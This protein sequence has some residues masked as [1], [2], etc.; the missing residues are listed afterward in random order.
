MSIKLTKDFPMDFYWGG[1]VTATQTEGNWDVDGK[2]VCPPDL[3]YYEPGKTQNDTMTT[4]EIQAALDDQEH[5]YPR[6]HA[7]DFYH[8]YKEDI[9]LLKEM[10][11]NSFRTSI[12]W[13]RIFPNGDDLEPNPKGIEF[14]DNVINELLKNDIEPIITLSHFEMPINLSLKY[15]GWYSRE[16]IQFF[17]K[18]VESLFIHFKGRVKYWIPFDE[19]NLIHREGFSQFGMPADII[20]NSLENR[21]RASHNR[22]LASALATD[23]AHRIDS[24]NKIASMVLSNYA[25]PLTSDPKDVLAAQQNDQFENYYLDVM[26]RGKY[27]NR[28]LRFID[29]HKF[30]IGYEEEDTAVFEKGKA[31]FIGLSYYG[32]RTVDK[33][34]IDL[35]PNP[36]VDNPNIKK[37]DWGWLEDASGLR[38]SL[39]K[40]YDQYQVPIFLME[41]GTG[42][43]DELVNGQVHDVQRIEFFQ[44]NLKQLKETIYDGVELIGCLVWGP[45]DIVSNS[46]AEMSKRYGF[47]YVDIDDYGKGS[48]KRYKK[49]SFAWFR[50]VIAENGKNI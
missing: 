47:I 44:E 23:L 10:G 20:E 3:Y 49:D 19:L 26:I 18:Y 31:D 34:S 14:Y 41:L 35:W 45:I 13:A 4:A 21:L 29:E 40:I 46:S 50:N 2:G 27:P 1:A 38:Y 6:R 16:V 33:E 25:Y 42:T 28:M 5:Y 43:H 48:G 30:D 32:N 37:N 39:N 11:I 22:L 8:T 12:N 7:I 36:S 24:N 15:N 17:L 9:A